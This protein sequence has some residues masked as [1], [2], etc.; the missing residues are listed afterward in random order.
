MQL[1][2]S[3]LR[4]RGDHLHDRLRRTDAVPRRTAPSVRQRRDR[5]DGADRDARVAG[6][7]DL[8]SDGLSISGVGTWIAA[9]VI[10]WLAALVAAFCCRSSG[11]KY[12]EDDDELTFRRRCRPPRA[13]PSSCRSPAEIKVRRRRGRQGRTTS[14]QECA[15]PLLSLVAGHRSAILRAVSVPSGWSSR[16]ASRVGPPARPAVRSSSRTCSSAPARSSSPRGRGRSKRGRRVRLAGDEERRARS[17]RSSA[18]TARSR[19]G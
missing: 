19:P 6:H 12:L 5:C 1:I 13:D 4:P 14:L 7:P 15:E 3:R 9:A 2:F 17:R 11:S 10:V 18:G 8:L 16:A